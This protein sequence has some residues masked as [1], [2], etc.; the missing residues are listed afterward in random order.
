VTTGQAGHLPAPSSVDAVARGIEQ[1][2]DVQLDIIGAGDSVADLR[3][4][5]VADGLSNQVTIGRYVPHKTVLE[6]STC[7]SVGVVPNL[8]TP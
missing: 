8:P 1:G 4:D 3:G 6:R 2:V 5:V 7:A